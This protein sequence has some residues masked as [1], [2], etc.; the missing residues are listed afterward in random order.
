MWVFYIV[1]MERKCKTGGNRQQ[2]RTVYLQCR[3][4]VRWIGWTLFGGAD[5]EMT[6]TKKQQLFLDL[7][8]EVWKICP[9]CGGW[10]D[11]RWLLC[12]C[13]YVNKQEP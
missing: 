13:G 9:C 12:D 10:Y 2:N 7:N 5:M 4:N 1:V 3:R 8:H 11:A 6:P